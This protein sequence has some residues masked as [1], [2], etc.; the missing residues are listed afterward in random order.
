MRRMRPASQPRRVLAFLAAIALVLA[1]VDAAFQR[2]PAQAAGLVDPVLGLVSVCA[3]DGS[4]TAPER[5]GGQHRDLPAHC[6]VCTLL[7]PLA[8]P[9]P[10]LPETAVV[11][12]ITLLPAPSPQGARTLADHLGLGGIRSRAPPLRA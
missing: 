7:T 2:A 10:G 4:P 11:F 6:P 9:G 1:S 12:A 8:L 3:A 5:G